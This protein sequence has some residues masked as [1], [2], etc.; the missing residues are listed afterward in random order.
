MKL[1]DIEYKEVV[2]NEGKIVVFACGKLSS[3]KIVKSDIKKYG[4]DPEDVLI[5]KEIILSKEDFKNFNKDYFEDY[6]FL[7][8]VECGYDTELEK[9]LCI[10]VTDGSES[11]VVNTEGYSYARHVGLEK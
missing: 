3:L 2:K 1:K 11:V 10:R 8:N 5:K 7:K 9:S 4:G 6:K